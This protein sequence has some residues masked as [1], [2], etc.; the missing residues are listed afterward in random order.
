MGG[1]KALG[2]IRFEIRKGSI[3]NLLGNP[4]F[5]WEVPNWLATLIRKIKTSG[6]KE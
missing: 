2:K 6:G 1:T 4:W 5:I 3:I